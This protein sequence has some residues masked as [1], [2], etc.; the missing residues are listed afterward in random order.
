MKTR[1]C[2]RCNGT[3]LKNT[4]VTHLGVPGLCYGCNGSGCQKWVD[5]AIVTAERQAQ[6]AAHVAEVKQVIA[7]CEAVLASGQRV[8][9]AY[10]RELAHQRQILASLPATVEAAAGEW[11][12]APRA[13]VGV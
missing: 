8:S 10:T 9:S 3:G 6:N 11:R 1:T 12:P 2:K 4:G 5:A 7:N 13:A